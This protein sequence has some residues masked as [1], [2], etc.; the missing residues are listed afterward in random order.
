MGL[1]SIVVKPIINGSVTAIILRQASNKYIKS[2]LGKILGIELRS[3]PDASLP[4]FRA[5]QHIKTTLRRLNN[6]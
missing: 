1:Q 5:L 6:H 3:R 4:A 2:A